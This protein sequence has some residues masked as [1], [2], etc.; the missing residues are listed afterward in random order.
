MSCAPFY[1]YLKME[2][3]CTTVYFSL[4]ESKQNKNGES[5]I[6]VSSVM[7]LLSATAFC[8]K[9]RILY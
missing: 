9:N 8:D 5:P 3:H 7:K 2:K 6:E 1:F 4:R